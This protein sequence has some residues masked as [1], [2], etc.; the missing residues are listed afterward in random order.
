MLDQTFDWDLDLFD[1]QRHH[2]V[3][4]HSM[5]YGFGR[6]QVPKSYQFLIDDIR[7][8]GFLETK[9]IFD[10]NDILKIKTL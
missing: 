10:W 1:R 6:W 7:E 9:R 8:N 5:K 2:G 4:F 3:N